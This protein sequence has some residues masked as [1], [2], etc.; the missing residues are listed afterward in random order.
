MTIE[1]VDIPCTNTE[2]ARLDVEMGLCRLALPYPRAAVKWIFFLSDCPIVRRFGDL[3][4]EAGPL[5]KLPWPNAASFPEADRRRLAAMEVFEREG[6]E[7]DDRSLDHVIDSL[8]AEHG[9]RHHDGTLVDVPSHD[10][11]VG[12]IREVLDS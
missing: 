3:V 12:Q 8:R 11:I 10:A 7:S 4:A 9:C 1:T 2:C 6:P 5:P